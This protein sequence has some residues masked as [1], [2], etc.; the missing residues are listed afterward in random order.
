MTDRDNYLIEQFLSRELTPGEEKELESRLSDPEFMAQYELSQ[1]TVDA[2]RLEGREELRTQLRQWDRIRQ[3]NKRR[4][5][6]SYIGAA[7]SIALLVLFYFVLSKPP[8]PE[9]LVAEYLEPYPNVIAPLQKGNSD[10]SST[11][12]EAFRFYEMGYYGKAESGFLGEDHS[13]EAV[14]FYRGLTALLDGRNEVARALLSE[15]AE[16]SEH[17]FHIPGMWYY[18]LSLIEVNKVQEAKKYLGQV[19]VSDHPL[20]SDA[21]KLLGEI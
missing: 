13:D 12:E 19:A 17:R 5:L 2:I 7:A 11:Y 1:K 9:A 10:G 18:S 6:Y 14:Q 21:K 16:D 8:A 4:Q 20:A 3:I 15:V